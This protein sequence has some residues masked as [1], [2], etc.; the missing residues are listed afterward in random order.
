MHSLNISNKKFSRI[1][2]HDQ[3]VRDKNPR[4]LDRPVIPSGEKQPKRGTETEKQ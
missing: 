1:K 2:E 4:K 3:A